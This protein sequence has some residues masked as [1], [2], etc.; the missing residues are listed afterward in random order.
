MAAKPPVIWQR[1]AAVQ[2]IHSDYFL[3]DTKDSLN[4]APALTVAAILLGEGLAVNCFQQEYL[5]ASSGSHQWIGSNAIGAATA[6]STATPTGSRRFFAYSPAFSGPYVKKGPG[7]PGPCELGAEGGIRTP[8]GLLQLAPEASASAVPPLPQ[9]KE[10]SRAGT[11]SIAQ[12]KPPV[13]PRSGAT[14]RASSPSTASPPTQSSCG[15][16]S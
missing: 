6:P 16:R 9:W 10:S 11:A 14:A 13:P 15:P 12:P 3:R 1:F 8:T 2:V 5:R 7:T 4:A